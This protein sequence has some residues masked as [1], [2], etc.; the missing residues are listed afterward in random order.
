MTPVF[1]FDGVHLISPR[2][3]DLHF[4]AKEI[5]LNKKYFQDKGHTIPHYDVWGEPRSKLLQFGSVVI[6][7]SKELV[8]VGRRYYNKRRTL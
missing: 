5:G 4:I 3:D 1:Y 6:V 7:D 2:L 8:E